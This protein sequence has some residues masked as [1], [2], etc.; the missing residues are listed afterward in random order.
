MRL[1]HRTVISYHSLMKIAFGCDHAGFDFK[2]RIIAELKNMGHE[3][4][5]FGTNSSDSCDYPDFGAAAARAV[6]EGKADKGIVVCGSGIG[7]S[8]AAN[9]IKGIRCALCHDH[10]MAQLSRQHNDAN[11][12]AFGS[13]TVGI[14]VALDMIH[15]FLTTEFEGGRH[16]TRVKK[17]MEL[18]Q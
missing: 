12:L 10:L 9:K 14:Q 16:A 3:V 5:D 8:L 17:L 4:L 11:M 13:R 18:D 15:V 6:A 2:E 1:F 7:I